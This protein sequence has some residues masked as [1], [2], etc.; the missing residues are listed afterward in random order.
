MS[1]TDEI[2]E[3]FALANVPVLELEPTTAED[4][5]VRLAKHLPSLLNPPEA[6]AVRHNEAWQWMGE[7]VGDSKAILWFSEHLSQAMFEI[8]GGENVVKVLGESTWDP[9]LITDYEGSYLLEYNDHNHLIAYGKAMVWLEQEAAKRG[10]PLL[11]DR[12]PPE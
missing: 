10:V 2:H 9:M 1:F 11:R 6:N 12:K 5:R 8:A 3:A 7:Y 4:V